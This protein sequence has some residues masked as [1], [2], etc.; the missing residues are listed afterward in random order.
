MTEARTSQVS[1]DT[2]QPRY[3]LRT[4]IL[5]GVAVVLSFTALVFKMSNPEESGGLLAPLASYLA[6]SVFLLIAP[7]LHI[8]SV[9]SA[10]QGLQRGDGVMGGLASQL[11]NLLVLGLDFLV[12]AAALVGAPA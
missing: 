3:Y 9:V 11:L 8:A 5:T 10:V 7:I 6:L 1:A 4:V 2:A 12:G